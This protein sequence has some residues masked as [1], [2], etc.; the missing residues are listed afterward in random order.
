[1]FYDDMIGLIK[2]LNFQSVHPA[3]Q[4][5]QTSPMLRQMLSAGNIGNNAPLSDTFQKQSPNINKLNIYYYNDTHGNSDQMA[6]LVTAAK[7]FKKATEGSQALILSA[8]DN[9]SGGDAKKNSFI[10]D[11]MQDLIG[12]DAS[13]VGNHEIDATKEGFLE[14]LKERKMPFIATNAEFENE[15][16]KKLIKKSQIIEKNGVKYGLVG[17][18]PIDFKLCTKEKV[19]EGIEVDDFDDTVEHLQ[20]EIEKLKQEGVDKIILLSHTSY[21]TDK[22]L[23]K[24]LDGVD[25]IIGGHSH[26]VVEGTK[27]G[28]NL[29]KSKS[30]EPVIITQAGEN[31]QYFGNLEVEFDDKGILTRVNNR[32]TE[33]KNREKSPVIE[34]I[35]DTAL[36]KSKTV[37]KLTFVEP[38]PD[39]RRITPCGWTC[40]MADS[41]KEELGVDIALINSANI[42]KVPKNGNLT[43]RDIMESA[44][45]KNNLLITRITQKQLT[46]AIK[47]SAKQTF[48][49]Q[50]GEPG[51]IQCSG[52]SY[53]INKQG[54]LLEL[55]II[56]KEGKK[57]PVDINN[58]S[59]EITYS[60]VY[61]TFMAQANGETPELAPKFE[62]KQ[63]DYDKDRTMTDYLSKMPNVNNIQI[64]Y[65][66]RIEIV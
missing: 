12:V 49:S 32:L 19:Q 61:D 42:R 9:C 28:E 30:G 5:Q 60:A 3:S 66:N 59:E 31:G 17:T 15:A 25:I 29:V 34:H 62:V 39:N 48:S 26:T 63:L 27:E 55:N 23:A 38:L 13:A 11:L 53:K 36:G 37:G 24:N 52:V 2:N 18:M 65:D 51:L 57:T 56:D 44:P 8:G 33:N 6:G 50:N 64:R 10:F 54:E 16:L 14:A 45:M 46:E 21:E 1:M 40:T 20:E 58:P 41:M 22:Q 4:Q 43:E 35:K 47:N 7:D